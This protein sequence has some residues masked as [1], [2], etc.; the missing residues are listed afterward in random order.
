MAAKSLKQKTINGLS[1]SFIDNIA[2]LSVTF[3]VGI[4]LAR[5]LMPAEFGLLGMITV[6]I[7]LSNSFIDSG[8]GSALIR[9][10]DCTQSD[11][12]TVFFYNLAV[13]ICMYLVL[14]FSAGAISSFFNEP[15]LK[16]IV[17]VVGVGVIINSLTII[18]RTILTKNINFKLQAKI[19]FIAA[20][21]SGITAIILAYQGF[22]V[23]ALII[24]TL[25]FS[26]LTSLMLWLWNNWKPSL[27]FSKKSFRE[28]FGFGSK[29]LIS[30]LIDTSYKNIYYIIIGK[31]FSAADLGFYTRAS[32][33][34]NLPSKSLMGVLSKVTYPVLASIQNDIPRL[35]ANYKRM[36]RGVMFINFILLLG[37]GAIAE[38]MIY[39][40]IGE[41]WAPSV[42][43]LQIM[44]FAGMMYPVH[45]LNLNMLKVQGRSDLFLKLEV[46]KKLIAIPTIIIGIL[47]GIKFMLLGMVVNSQIAYI[48]NSYW[49]GKK[50]DYS[51]R[52]QVLDI[53]P[54]F[55]LALTM[56][57]LVFILGKI[58]PFSN[59][60]KLIIMI[61]SG[62]IF[63]FGTCELTRFRDY[64]YSK[65]LI[66]EQVGKLIK[67]RKG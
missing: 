29:L 66:V 51:Y 9:K 58:L 30:G 5:L 12:S 36:I 57:V 22:G 50:I 40:L 23:W 61:L 16:P 65:E 43:Y 42:I 3:I 4:I 56:A 48:I 39:T 19:S 59:P 1:W 24:Q 17:R 2:N 34:K 21:L 6:F 18:Q 25:S 46:L 33:F 31:Y 67:R 64:I 38:P 45:V 8:F 54:S 27:V 35:K 63:I 62:A 11:Y 14:Y 32:G 55:L 20:L 7:A 41:K 15:I 37:L 52:E 26:A 53:L 10:V 47:W 13:G 28:L 44:V 60:V 49:S